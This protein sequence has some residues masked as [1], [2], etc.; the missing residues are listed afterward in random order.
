MD[1][2]TSRTMTVTRRARDTGREMGARRR[3]NEATVAGALV[4]V[5][6]KL[7]RRRVA[8]WRIGDLVRD[9]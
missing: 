6:E 2:T 9:R 1:A 3:R 5:V 7:L 8:E 4:E